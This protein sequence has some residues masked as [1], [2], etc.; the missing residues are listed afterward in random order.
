MVFV[1]VID[2]DVCV[3]LSGFSIG[4]CGMALT[5]PQVIM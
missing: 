2:Y 3:C 4:L 5:T 1:R